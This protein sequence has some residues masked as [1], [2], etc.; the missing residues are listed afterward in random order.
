M[1]PL[2]G[3]RVAAVAGVA[4]AGTLSSWWLLSQGKQQQTTPNVGCAGLLYHTNKL[5]C[6]LA[7]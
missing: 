3:G 1:S 7:D 4:A 2:A 6:N 5:V